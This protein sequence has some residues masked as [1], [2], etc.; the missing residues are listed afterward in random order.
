MKKKHV[1]FGIVLLIILIISVLFFLPANYYIRQALLHQHPKINQYGIFENK[2]VKADNPQPWPLSDYYNQFSI[3]EQY[4]SD[5]EKLGT[6]AYVV[7]QNGELLFEQYWDNYSELSLS[8]SFSMSKSLVSL[9]VGCA[10]DDGFIRNTDQPVSDFFSQFEG[11]NGKTLTLRHLLTM[12]AGF[13]FEETYSSIFS[14]TTQL[15]Y[16]NDLN[17]MTFNMKSIAEPGVNFIYQSGVTQLLAYI[18][19]KATGDNISDYVSR[20]IWTPIQAE[21]NALWSLDHKDGMEKA[22]CCFNSNARDFARI[23]QLILNKGKWHGEQ[24]I[25]SRYII[26]ATTADESLI[27]KE[28][29][30]EDCNEKNKQYGFQFWTLE[31]NG[32][33]IPYMRG[34]LGQYI[35]VIPEKNAVVVRLG[36]KK[37]KTYTADQHYPADIDIWLNAA[38]KILERCPKQAR[39]VFGGD[40]MQ[41]LPQVRA[42]HDN[43]GKGYDYSESFQYVKSIFDQGLAI[44]NLETTIT[45][46]GNYSGYPMFRSPTELTESL[47][48]MGIDVAVMANN[49]VF[50]G[51]RQGVNTTLSSLESAGILHTGV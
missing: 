19:Q 7:I 45:A 34:L 5:F 3:P 4:I 42:A 1:I 22:Y 32:K 18:I 50:D 20:R 47:C 14:P 38:D 17:A 51:G 26:D 41:H 43:R 8:N 15:Y 9:A 23:G 31:R 30:Q 35:F 44:I 33:K 21:E 48:N 40:L 16:G 2:I 39:L 11:F 10:I 36:R 28:C 24:V 37:F 29:H 6:V 13:D 12:S 46:S 25:S 49:H 27:D